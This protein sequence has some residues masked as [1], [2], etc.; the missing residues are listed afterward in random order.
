MNLYL[1]RHGECLG[2]SDPTYYSDPDSPLS[3]LGIE[4]ALLTANYFFKINLTHV[5]SSPLIRSL[6]TATPIARLFNLPV[7]VWT[8]AREGFS[9]YHVGF[10]L[11][12]LQ[13]EFPDAQFSKEISETGWHHGND[14]YEDWKIR[15][16]QVM[17]KLLQLPHNSHIVL[18]SHGGFSNYFL[19]S[20]LSI[21]FEKPVWFE[22]ANGSVS[23]I[24]FVPNPD[25]ER[26]NWPLYPP[27]KIEI[28]SINSVVHL[29]VG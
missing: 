12:K 22:L 10:S 11:T 9:D 16:K 3:S 2:Q 27:V 24:R 1:I 13:K 21:S 5:I 4:Q 15:C 7:L 28:H 25:T 6:A 19:H 23:H 14:K 29:G 26:P 8:E 17:E 18:V 20:A